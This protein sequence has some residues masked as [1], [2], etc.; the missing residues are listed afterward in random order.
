MKSLGDG[1]GTII[2][3]SGRY[4][5]CAV[6]TGANLTLRAATSSSAIFEGGACEGKATLVLRGSSATVDG[7]VFRG[8]RVP[9]RNGSGIRLE[10][11]NLNVIR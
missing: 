6:F 5:D 4:P 11:G 10:R 7:I 3:A 2:V 8:I 9:D 1:S